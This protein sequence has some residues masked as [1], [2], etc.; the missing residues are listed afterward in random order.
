[1]STR[2][3]L[4]ALSPAL[5]G[6]A[7]CSDYNVNSLCTSREPVF[8][9]EEVSVVETA[10][11]PA[12]WTS[13]AVSLDAI[14]PVNPDAYWRV[15]AVDVLV[16][17][18]TSHMD[19]T[20]PLP[21]NFEGAPLTVEVFDSGNPN[22]PGAQSWSLTQNL[23]TADLEWSDHTF[24]TWTNA[25]ESEYKMAWWSFNISEETLGSPMTG[26]RFTVGLK[27][28]EDNVPEVG[29]SNFNRPCSDN[30]TINTG[31]TRYGNNGADGDNND[32]SWP[33][34]RVESEVVWESAGDCL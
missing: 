11:G 2:T 16:M 29:Y 1:M 13:D 25:L 5:L 22:D 24:D 14:P 27:W 26:E 3:A 23:N 33:M 7:S 34:F 30:W 8:D 9:I 10:W 15:V 28:P 19:G 18:P 4:F 6:L 20:S 21:S 31:E 17:V 32:C 12:W